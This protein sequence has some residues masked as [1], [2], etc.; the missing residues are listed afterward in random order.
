MLHSYSNY[1]RISLYFMNLRNR[2]K[3]A[4]LLFPIPKKRVI[5]CVLTDVI[6][7]IKTHKNKR[8]Y[9]LKRTKIT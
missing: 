5:K 4:N 7:R 2:N 3:L 9:A 6:K 8:K 1:V